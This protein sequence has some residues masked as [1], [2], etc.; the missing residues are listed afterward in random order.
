[1]TYKPSWLFIGLELQ[2][3]KPRFLLVLTMWEKYHRCLKLGAWE[4]EL[5]S[6]PA[7]KLVLFT[8][9]NATCDS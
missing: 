9:R 5:I 1:M 4:I 3:T 6:I 7:S 8:P 2:I